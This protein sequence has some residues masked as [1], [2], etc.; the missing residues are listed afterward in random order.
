M[1]YDIY[2]RDPITNETMELDEPH[3]M[4]GGTYAVGGESRAY[5]NITYNYGPI[6]RQVLGPEGVRA[7]YGMT[8]AESLPLLGTAIDHL[9]TEPTAADLAKLAE[10]KAAMA[11]AEFSR[12]LAH[13]RDD[14]LAR[15]IEDYWTP[16]EPNVRTAL[17]ALLALA[18][19]CPEGVWDGN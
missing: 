8:G 2:L 9:A 18:Q 19:A 12:S 6:L 14:A 13:L 11:E 17:L 10:Y 16:T 4:R 7:I 15:Q 3:Q 5:F 1:S